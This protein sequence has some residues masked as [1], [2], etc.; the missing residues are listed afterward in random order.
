MRSTCDIFYI[1]RLVQENILFNDV[2]LHKTAFDLNLNI[3][4]D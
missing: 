4:I 3:S 2:F 1:I